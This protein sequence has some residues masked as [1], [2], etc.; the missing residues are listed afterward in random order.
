MQQVT[1]AI[2]TLLART[3]A[4]HNTCCIERSASWY[5]GTTI[6]FFSLSKCLLT[7][8]FMHGEDISMHRTGFDAPPAFII[9]AI[10]YYYNFNN[11]RGTAPG[12]SNI[13]Y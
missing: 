13:T 11:D 12:D 9:C 3:V 6:A 4:V 2:H 5:S 7:L 1:S 10:L 8:A